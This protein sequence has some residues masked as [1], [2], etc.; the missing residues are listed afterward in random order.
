MRPVRYLSG[1]F[2]GGKRL[3]C[4]RS[5]LRYRRGTLDSAYSDELREGVNTGACY[6]ML[7]LKLRAL[8]CFV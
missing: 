6:A 5:Q 1:D 2:Y 3:E 7:G 8:S 4:T